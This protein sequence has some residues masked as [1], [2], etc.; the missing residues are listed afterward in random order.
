MRQI[1]VYHRDCDIAV[2]ACNR[3][4]SYC[5]RDGSAGGGG[6]RAVSL[7]L[8]NSADDKGSSRPAGVQ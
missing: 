5:R 8:G 4:P 3:H 1:G 2:W 7:P 6:D